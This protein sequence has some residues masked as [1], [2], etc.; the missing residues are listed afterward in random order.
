VRFNF[1]QRL[2]H[3]LVSVAVFAFRKTRQKEINI[4]LDPGIGGVFA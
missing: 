1:V 3:S 4:L 2:F